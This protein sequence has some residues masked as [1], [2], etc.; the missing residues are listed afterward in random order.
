LCDKTALLAQSCRHL[1]EK[2]FM[3]TRR[4]LHGLLRDI[5]SDFGQE[6]ASLH[7]DAG[8]AYLAW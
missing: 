4:S 5:H 6:K 8:A 3:R 2:Y 7:H 1:R